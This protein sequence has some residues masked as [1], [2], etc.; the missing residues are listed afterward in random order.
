VAQV[1]S[2]KFL[3]QALADIE[4]LYAFLDSKS[5]EAAA[6]AAAIILDGAKLLQSMP[7]IGRP[8]PDETGRRELFMA[9]R[10]G[11]YVLRYM[12]EG[13]HTIVIIR[14]WH[15]REYRA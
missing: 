1:V 7:R 13:D 11:A 10:A 9:F 3:P 15:S 4:R 8:M 5:P 12:Q 2:V 14:V 6:K